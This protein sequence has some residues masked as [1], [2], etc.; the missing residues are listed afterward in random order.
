MSPAIPADCPH[1]LRPG[2]TVCF[3]CRA[4]ARAATRR[5]VH[6]AAGIGAAVIASL[7][8]VG[9]AG[10]AVLGHSPAQAITTVA[11]LV[12]EGEGSVTSGAPLPEVATA[13]P[14]PVAAHP[15]P[16]TTARQP[17]ASPS[18]LAVAP[19]LAQGRTEL[20]EGVHA[21]RAGDTVDVHFDTPNARTRRRDKFERIVR[22]TL[23]AIYGDPAVQALGG[24]PSGALLEN[25]D[26]ITELPHRG[27]RIPMA[28]GAALSV[29]PATRPGRDGPLVVSYRVA[30]SP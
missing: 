1:E 17:E 29:W 15:A 5:R 8:A 10:A 19:K 18:L 7:A 28:T 4:S 23:P 9:A 22:A 25:G 13:A 26:L 21:E 14:L 6:R 12:T 24:V 30:V 27:V 3:H 20:G 2:V 16:T 11:R